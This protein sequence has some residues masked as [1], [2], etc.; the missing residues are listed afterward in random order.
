L[1][2]FIRLM[3]VGFKC[4]WPRGDGTEW[5]VFPDAETVSG[6]SNS[7][8]NASKWNSTTQWK[9]GLV[10]KCQSAAKGYF[11]VTEQLRIGKLDVAPPT[12]PLAMLPV[13]FEVRIVLAHK[14]KCWISGK[15]SLD[16]LSG[17]VGY[18]Q[19]TFDAV[20]SS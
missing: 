3:G 2:N 18:R 10:E 19:P 15:H 16:F 1:K 9:L 14:F 8:E 17:L 7:L 6:A 12:D 11:F 5:C 20:P 4:L 13:K